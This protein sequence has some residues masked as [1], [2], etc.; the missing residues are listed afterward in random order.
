MNKHAPEIYKIEP[1]LQQENL[2]YSQIEEFKQAFKK[3]LEFIFQFNNPSEI[4][5]A[6]ILKYKP[7]FLN[8]ILSELIIL[9]KEKLIDCFFAEGLEYNYLNEPYQDYVYGF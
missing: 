8:R 2:K 1:I 9:K 3:L 4:I 7:F 6:C 5:K